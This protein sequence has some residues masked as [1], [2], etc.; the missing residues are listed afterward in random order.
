[1]VNLLEQKKPLKISQSPCKLESDNG[2]LNLQLENDLYR[3]EI[4]AFI[5]ADLGSSNIVI[6]KNQGLMMLN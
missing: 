2:S 6:V 4:E 5:K 3:L 1:M